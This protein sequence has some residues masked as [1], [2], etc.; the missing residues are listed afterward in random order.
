MTTETLTNLVSEMAAGSLRV[1]DLTVPLSAATP[2]IGLPEEFS[3]SPAFK[4]EQISHYDDR[5]PAWYWN[6]FSCGEH[7]G[8]HFDA[9][10]HWITGQDYADGYTDTI[11]PGKLV[12]AANVID[13]S[14]ESA[15]NPDFLLT[16]DRIREWEAV[17]GRIAAGTW[18]LMRTD[19]SKRTAEDFLNYAEDGP[20]TPGPS[21]ECMEFLAHD[22]DIL[23]FGV[24]TV[25]TD[26]G[27]AF[28]FDPAFPAHQLMHSNNKFGLAS[29][30]NLDQLPPTGAVII[31]PPLKIVTG[32]GS[33]LRVLALTSV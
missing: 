7:T 20:H 28:T 4:L 26:A 15:E 27:Q 10:G 24:E 6:S 3:P 9:P 19:W 2:V 23:G 32:S 13:V 1:V 17:H 5:G 29:L 12:A 21:V 25:G 22:R 30:T 18:V 8:T 14:T 31:T 16:S 11:P 33:P